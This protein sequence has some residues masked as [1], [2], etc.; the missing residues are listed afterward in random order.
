MEAAGVPIDVAAWTALRDEA[1]ATLATVDAELAELLPGVN[2]D[3][4][5]QLLS[6]LA[7]LGINIPTRRRPPSAAL[8]IS[9]PPSSWCCAANR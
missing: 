6:A 7:D 2:V 5:A 4:P 1:A 8:L 3:S 9:I